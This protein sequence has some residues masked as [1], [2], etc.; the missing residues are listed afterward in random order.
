MASGANVIAFPGTSA[1]AGAFDDGLSDELFPPISRLKRQYQDYLG[2]KSNENA[3]A[4]ECRRYYHGAQW[5]AEEL[6][7]LRGRN[8][9]PVTYNRIAR[10]INGVV[11]LIEKLR[12]DPR[13]YPRTPSTPAADGAELATL[14]LNQSLDESAW[15]DLCPAIGQKVAAV[16]IGGIE[17]V[18]EQGDQGDPVISHVEVDMR[19]YFYDPRSTK[20]DFTD[21]R[22]Q[23]TSKWVDLDMA[24]D[25]WPDLAEELA[26]YVET[27]PMGAWE[28]GDERDVRWV[29]LRQK[30][31]RLVDHW[32]VRG[33]QWYYII[34][35]GE[36]VLER[37]KSPHFDERRRS[38]PKYIMTSCFVDHENDRY[39]MVRDFKSPQDE[40]NH[41][42]S[43]AL[44]SL[45]TRRIEAEK[46][47]FDDPELTRREAARNDGYIERNPG[48]EAEIKTNDFDFKG[49]LELLQE[50][51]AEIDNFGPSPQLIN[52][53]IDVRSGRA[54][55]LLQQA[56]IAELGPFMVGW[57]A[58]KLRVYRFT[59]NAIQQFWTSERWIRVTDDE[60]L[61][62]FVQVN[63]WERDQ[64]GFPVVVNKLA[65]LDIDIILDEGPDQVN[66]MADAFDTL[67]ALAQNGA[68]VP[69]A[70][71]I[72]LSALPSS[73]KKKVMQ[74]LT[75][76][77]QPDPAE[78]QAK[79][80]KL[81][82]EEAKIGQIQSTTQ[83]NIAQAQAALTPAP[84][85]AQQIDTQADLAKAAKDMAQARQIAA[86][87]ETGGAKPLDGIKAAKEMASARE[88]N[89]RAEKIEL[90]TAY[91]G[92]FDKP[93][94]PAK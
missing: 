47:A 14:V 46:G 77:Q 84:G 30:R 33:K 18:I 23:G 93:T 12:Q 1:P 69:P 58:W 68:N 53:Q 26:A 27:A 55:A 73:I 8:Q 82:Q 48:Y 35:A 74:L 17:I 50:A 52:A 92:I 25:T 36:I 59:W 72:E 78:Q 4:A 61:I 20:P 6:N 43:K 90:E 79:Q 65:A 13:A 57:R 22:Y 67:I 5:T 70:V 86:D 38:V 83:K 19:D 63:G 11:G 89:A 62:S 76:A 88:S 34:Y 71:I 87:I 28:H 39:S 54:I 56:G 10:K 21:A 7:T 51:K 94:A 91:P 40:T 24:Q 29:D 75:S 15:R 49:N 37:G 44:H 3:E 64:F 85:P 80:I 32:F 60:G 42:R 41:R 45:N 2:A 16:G 81:A 9:P 66:T 31:I